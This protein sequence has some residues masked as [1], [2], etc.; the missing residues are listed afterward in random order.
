M[1]W[2]QL[3]LP[4]IYMLLDAET[5]VLRVDSAEMDVTSVFK[6]RFQ[7]EVQHQGSEVGKFKT[8]Q[9]ASPPCACCGAFAEDFG[10]A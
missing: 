4:M 6:H 3:C 9:A 10:G 7:H 8:W 5:R 2:Q 1:Q